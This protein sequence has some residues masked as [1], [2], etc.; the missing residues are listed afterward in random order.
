MRADITQHEI[1]LRPLADLRGWEKNPRTITKKG[2]ANLRRKI[3][4]LGLYKPLITLQDG[5]VIGGNQRLSVLRDMEVEKVYCSILPSDLSDAALLE[6]AISDNENDGSWKREELVMLIK[7]TP[8]D[9]SLY[10]VNF[11]EPIT[12][13]RLMNTQDKSKQDEAPAV[14]DKSVSKPGRVYQLGRHRVMCADATLEES[15][16]KLMDG[17]KADLYLTDPP[18]NVGKVGG[19]TTDHS[20]SGKTIQNDV[21]DDAEFRAFLGDSFRRADEV[22][23]KGASFYIWHADSEGLNF[24][25][26]CSDVYWSIRQCLVWD[27]GR[28]VPGRQD[29]QWE[30]EPCLYGWKSGASHNWY[31]DRTQT[32]VLRFDRP[33]SSQDH[34]TMKPIALMAYLIK[35]NT[36]EEDIVLDNFLG[37]GSTLIAAE[38]TG[39]TCYGMELDP[40]Y[41]DVIRK[42]YAALIE[43]EDWK[44]ATPEVS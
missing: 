7:E 8:I 3:E 13:E 39:R 18:Y 31:S 6:I 25:L 2:K 5:T 12:L 34:P 1:V 30:H 28:L 32:T 15:Y 35:N 19:D 17:M 33:T 36:K 22:M 10:A 41:V 27:N 24:R 44:Q 26:A 21:K 40:R 38:Q 11:S 16:V 42:R 20:R 29:Y 43:A 23:K 9:T 37:S 14:E 4:K